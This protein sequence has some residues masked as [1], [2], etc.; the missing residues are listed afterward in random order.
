MALPTAYLTSFKNVDSI[1][2]A[3]RSAQAPARFTQRFLEGLGFANSNDRLF[4]NVFKALGMLNE[5]GVPTRRYHEYLDQ[6]QSETVLAEAIRGAY[7]DLFLV[8]KKAQDMSTTEVKN[9]M[10][11]L[12]EGQ[13][14]D[15]VLTQMSGTFKILAKNADFGASPPKRP[16]AAD[17]G[18]TEQPETEPVQTAIRPSA[19]SAEARIGGLVYSI[20]VQL[21]ESRDQAVYDAIF[22]SLKE[23]LLR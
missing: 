6:T 10:K 13:Y 14:S 12:S 11:T 21:P 20:N 16:V 18:A 1:L 3:I 2:A 15:R 5:T 9:K 19:S 8:N 22:K 4:I 7:S 17:L 23:H